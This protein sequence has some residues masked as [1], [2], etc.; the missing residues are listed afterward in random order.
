MKAI[1]KSRVVSMVEKIS[2]AADK[3]S[4]KFTSHAHCDGHHHDHEEEDDDSFCIDS[5]DL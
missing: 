1:S 3:I 5:D 4:S 2:T